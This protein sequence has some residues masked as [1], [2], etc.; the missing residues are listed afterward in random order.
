MLVVDGQMEGRCY[1]MNLV[2]KFDDVGKKIFRFYII[3]SLAGLRNSCVRLD[4]RLTQKIASTV[5]R[6]SVDA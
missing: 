1:Q 3:R 2:T 6:R 4:A 5:S